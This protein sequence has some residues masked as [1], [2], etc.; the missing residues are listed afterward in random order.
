MSTNYYLICDKH[1][2]RTEACIRVANGLEQLASG[3]TLGPFIVTHRG[4]P[5]RIVS[6]HDHEAYDDTFKEW[7]INNCHDMYIMDR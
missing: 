6:E 7:T 1:L 2:E 4:C 3:R 5:I